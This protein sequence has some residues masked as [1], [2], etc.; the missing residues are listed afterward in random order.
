MGFKMLRFS[1]WILLAIVVYLSLKPKSAP[2]LIEVNDKIGHALAYS[3]LMANALLAFP[4]KDKKWLGFLLLLMGSFIEI[5]QGLIPGR[6]SSFNDLLA[7]ALGIMIGWLFVLIFGKT[8]LN[9][10]NKIKLTP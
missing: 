2:H 9:L 6:F 1:F 3:V 4:S 7:N 5:I 8:I 10:F